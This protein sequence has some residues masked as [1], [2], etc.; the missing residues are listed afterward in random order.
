MVEGHTQVA[1]LLS[2]EEKAM[3][4]DAGYTGVEKRQEH[5]DHDVIWQIVARRSTYSKLNKRSLSYK[6]KRKIEYCRAQTRAKVEYPFGS[7]S[8]SLIT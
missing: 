5:E 2:R 8:A 3:Y 1:E 7:S 6:A 4:A